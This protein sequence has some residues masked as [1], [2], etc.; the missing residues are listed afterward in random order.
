MRCAMAWRQRRSPMRH[1]KQKN[2]SIRKLGT[3]TFKSLLTPAKHSNAYLFSGFL[4]I[5]CDATIIISTVRI[6]GS[7]D[8]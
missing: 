1:T 6:E 7:A 4:E 2:Q 5:V 3:R 8:W